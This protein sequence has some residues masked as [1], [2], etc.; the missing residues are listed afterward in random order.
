MPIVRN[1]TK[2]IL[3]IPQGAEEGATL[4]L[5]PKGKDGDR[6]EVGKVS[7]AVYKAEGNKL[8]KIFTNKRSAGGRKKEEPPKP[9]PKAND[10]STKPDSP[11]TGE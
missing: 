2:T 11:R 5:A 1:E 4:K 3:L 9:Q 7:E 10:G 8:V 6:V